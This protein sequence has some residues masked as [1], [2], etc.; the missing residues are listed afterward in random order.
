MASVRACPNIARGLRR[1]LDGFSLRSLVARADFEGHELALLE[2]L[3]AAHLDGRVV[4]EDV[5]PAI[6]DGDEAVALFS[7]EPLDGSVRHVLLP[8]AF[9]RLAGG[10]FEPIPDSSERD[11][12]EKGIFAEGTRWS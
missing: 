8:A 2:D 7:V 6:L 4:D 11:A 10:C 5:L 3:V 12:S 9:R 1:E